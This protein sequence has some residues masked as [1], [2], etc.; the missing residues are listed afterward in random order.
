MSLTQSEALTIVSLDS[1][2]T[3]LRIP[4]GTPEHDALLSGQITSARESFRA[5]L[6]Y[7]KRK[8]AQAR[9]ES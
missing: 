2:K 3:E 8:A 7:Q 6:R 4:A 1:M 9:G 5:G